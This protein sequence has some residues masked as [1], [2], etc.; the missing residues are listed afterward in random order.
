M[1]D[2]NTSAKDPEL[3]RVRLQNAIHDFGPIS[4]ADNIDWIFVIGLDMIDGAIQN[5]DASDHPLIW[6]ELGLP[7]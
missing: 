5:S 7:K 6:A 3:Q 4:P 1:G 2:L